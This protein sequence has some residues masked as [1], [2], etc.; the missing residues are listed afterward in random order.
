LALDQG[1]CD[2]RGADPQTL[3]ELETEAVEQRGLCRSAGVEREQ[4]AEL[5]LQAARIERASRA[6]KSTSLVGTTS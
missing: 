4:A 2:E 5:P 6:T 3:G 1:W